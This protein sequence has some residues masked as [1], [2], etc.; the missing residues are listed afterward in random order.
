MTH[1][2]IIYVAG[3]RPNFVKIAP[4]LK[5]A[6]SFADWSSMLVHTGQHYDESLSASFFRSLDIKQPDRNLGVGSAGH[7]LQTARVLEAMDELIRDIKPEL[8][9]VV[10]DVN[11]TMASAL[12]AAKLHVPVAHV[13]AG[14]RSGDRRMPEE[15]NRILTDQLS[16]LCL[17][18][19]AD[20]NEHLRREGIA[21]DRIRFVGNIMIDSLLKKIESARASG[22]RR[23]LGLE[24]G[25]Y[26][27]ATLH[28]PSNVDD[29]DT[30]S[31]IVSAF[32][33]LADGRELVFPM[34]PR[35]AT[36]V[37]E[38]EIPTGSIRTMEPVG[39]LEMLDLMDGAAVVLTDSGGIQEETTVLGTPCLT[40]RSTTER[41]I[42]I[43]EGTNRLVPDRSTEAILSAVRG[44][45]PKRTLSRPKGWDG[46]AATRIVAELRTYLGLP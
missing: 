3:A 4:L 29:A 6:E 45:T 44:L 8:V 43:V 10:G 37:R 17:T 28:R 20:A 34:H 23:S 22:F 46:Q 5:Q 25:G 7:G 31:A 11:S 13:E 41:P 9:V 27:L 21:E 39:Y 26:L 14:L 16:D 36:R 32:R 12:A 24:R 42:T 18:P 30:L 35:T 33:Q 2:I 1:P 38:F 40:L 15:L 19:S